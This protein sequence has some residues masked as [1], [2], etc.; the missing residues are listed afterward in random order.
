MIECPDVAIVQHASG[1]LKAAHNL[2]ETGSMYHAIAMRSQLA[3]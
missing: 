2:F 3:Y 1:V